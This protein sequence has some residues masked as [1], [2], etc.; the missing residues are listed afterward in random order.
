MPYTA[1][2]A[3]TFKVRY[4]EFSG[5]PDA[6]VSAVLGEAI[7]QIGDDWHEDDRAQAQ[8]LL[9]AH[10]LTMEGEPERS[11]TIAAGGDI[12]G[13]TNGAMTSMKVG[14]VAVTYAD[15][16]ASGGG[17]GSMGSTEA[18]YRRT[19]YGARYYELMRRNIPSVALT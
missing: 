18:E 6:L 10:N 16:N 14:D 19:P 2:T 3:E 8:S 15:R 7:G 11:R 4:P 13:K 9:A 17:S 12:S 1:P 5:V